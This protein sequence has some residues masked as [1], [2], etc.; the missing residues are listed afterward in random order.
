MLLIAFISEY[1]RG[2][3]MKYIIRFLGAAVFFVTANLPILFQIPWVGSWLWLSLPCFLLLNIFPSPAARR[4]V[5]RRLRICADGCE[6]LILFLISTV[7]SVI[8]LLALI[9]V[10]FP[11]HPVLW[12]TNLLTVIVAEAVVFWNGIIRVYVTSAQIGLKWRVLGVACG[13]IPIAHLIVLWKLIRIASEETE[14]ENRK[15]LLNR[16]REGRMLCRTRYPILLVHGVF[17]RDFKYFN[18]WGRI[19]GELEKNGAEIYYGNHQSAAAV[20]DSASELS[21]RIQEILKE[22]GREKVNIIAHSKGGLDCRYAIGKLGMG[23]YVASLTTINTPHRG[24]EFADYLM[25]KCP[26]ALKQK[27]ADG[28]NAALKKLGD[29]KPD[30]LAAVT[31]L[32]ASAC[33]QFN[34]E[35]TDC[36]G[37][38]LQSVG[39]KLN[40]ASGGQ[41]PLN[42]SHRLVRYFDGP[43]DGLVSE[44]SFCWGSDYRFLTVN[45]PRGISH[46]DMIDLNRENIKNFDVREFYVELVSEL[47]EKG[48]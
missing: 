19:P 45:G 22:T 21:V 7:S 12:F 30:F 4:L 13:W 47:R 16:E 32:T 24:C 10:L 35:V 6:L 14:F 23:P 25:D 9:P 1:D 40:E 3:Y 20:A 42:F 17:F 28:Y 38:Y 41:F 2:N 27:T 8:L 44:K 39:S 5:Q 36:P 46:G 11:S 33:R 29:E 37:V 34:R 26:A 31:D 18:Y 43:N 48:F 15:L